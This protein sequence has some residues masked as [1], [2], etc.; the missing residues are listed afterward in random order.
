MEN[1][2]NDQINLESEKILEKMGI[3]IEDSDVKHTLNGNIFF[4][5]V[6][7]KSTLQNVCNMRL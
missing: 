3:D 5:I 7:I 2:N 4:F 6:I 1:I